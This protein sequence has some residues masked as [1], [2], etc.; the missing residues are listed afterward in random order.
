MFVVIEHFSLN[1]FGSSTYL[2]ECFYLS[3]V[4]NPTYL[5]V[6]KYLNLSLID[7]VVRYRTLSNQIRHSFF[8]FFT[9]FGSECKNLQHITLKFTTPTLLDPVNTIID[10]FLLDV[11]KFEGKTPILLI[12]FT[13][14]YEHLLMIL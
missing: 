10:F 11:T 7:S 6:I 14:H 2:F 9:V 8:S 3:R 4:V 12:F 13:L 5:F 1:R